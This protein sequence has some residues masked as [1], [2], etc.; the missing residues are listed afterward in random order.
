MRHLDLTFTA[1]LIPLDFLALLAAAITAYLL[2]FSDFFVALRPILTRI[3]LSQFLTTSVGFV[4]IWMLLFVV[5]GLYAFKPHRPWNELARII[6]ASTAGVMVLIAIVFFRRE[7][8]TSR[9]LVIAVWG[10]SIFYVFLG[11]TFLRSLRRALLSARIGHQKIVVIGHSKAAKDL[12]ELYRTRPALGLT[13]VKKFAAWNADTRKDVEA[14]AKKHLIDCV[15]LADPE[16]AKDDALELIGLSNIYHFQFRYLADLFAARFTNID[17]TTI[18]GIPVIEVKHT[19][20]DGWGRIAK[21]IFDLVVSGILIVIFSPIMLLT[22]MAIAL[23]SRGGVFFSRLPD[24]SKTMRIGEGATPFHYFKFRSMKQDTHWQRYK[25][26]AKHDLRKGDPLVKIK[27]DPRVTH[28]GKIIRKWSIDELPE[29]VLVFLGRMSLVGPR[30]HLPEEVEKY[31]P[32][33]RQVL[34][35][36]PGITGMAQI[37]GRSDLDFDEEVRLDI[38]YIENWS[39]WLDLS[40]LLKTPLAVVTHRGIEEGV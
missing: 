17:V 25:E 38:W 24:G 19:P 20:L 37:S 22:A 8:T 30:P 3:T 36:K 33:H 2:R 12:I 7:V 21:R 10:L 15:L 32:H 18:G 39:L 16:I 1:L 14:L 9:F 26:L 11:R 31:K 4:I 40:I 29:L 13:V 6:L 27:A 28:V 35:I 5:A 34:A 23:D